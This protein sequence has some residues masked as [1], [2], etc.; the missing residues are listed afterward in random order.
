MDGGW[1]SLEWW[2]TIQ[3]MV[4]DHTWHFTCFG[5]K[6]QV[7]ST[8]PSGR[9]WWGLWLVSCD[10]GKTKSTHCLIDLD[11]T[12]RLD[13]SLTMKRTSKIK[14][15]SKSKMTFK[16]KTALSWKRTT[17]KRM[18]TLNKKTIYYLKGANGRLSPS[19]YDHSCPWLIYRHQPNIVWP[20]CAL[21]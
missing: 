19:F 15:T 8:L 21:P 12:V 3:R 16:M 10:G 18:R 2:L 5:A 1:P 20:N 9:F 4:A 7:C 13:W 6:F 11:C 17:L 14:T